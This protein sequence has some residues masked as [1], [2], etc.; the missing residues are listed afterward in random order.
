MHSIMIAEKKIVLLSDLSVEDTV[1]SEYDSVI[2]ASGFESRC[3]YYA[4][5]YHNKTNPTQVFGF[6]ESFELRTRKESDIY[7]TEEL[8]VEPEISMGDDDIEILSYLNRLNVS[9][10][11]VRLLIDY[12]SMSR[13]WYGAILNWARFTTKYKSISLDFVYTLGEYSRSDE[14]MVI[15][16]IEVLPGFEG[17][18]GGRKKSVAIF[19][20]GFEGDAALSVYDRLEPD[21]LYT[22]F[23][24]PA[25]TEAA[26]KKVRSVNK[27]LRSHSKLCVGLPVRSVVQT[28]RGLGELLLPHASN[29]RITLVPMGPKPHILASLIEG[30]KNKNTTCLRVS[31]RA[32][33]CKD[34]KAIGEV[35]AT[36]LI[37]E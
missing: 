23:S 29:S 9:A 10:E 15:K 26:H 33:K 27:E 16:D 21:V 12:T 5:K 28:V 24:E 36:R 18:G 35:V 6:K 31:G 4:R 34:V 22:Y 32:E 11:N 37:F 25:A 13:Y 19:G 7:F 8:G 14:N 30:I 20:L 3:T 2:Y 17:F 1:C